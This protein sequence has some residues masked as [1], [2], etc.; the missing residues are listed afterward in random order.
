MVGEGSPGEVGLRPGS[1]VVAPFPLRRLLG[2]AAF[3][4]VAIV[5]VTVLL[6]GSDPASTSSS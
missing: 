1:R 3:W 5:W 4:A 6:A 2:L